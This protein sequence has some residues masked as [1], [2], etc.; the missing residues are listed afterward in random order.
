MDLI[1][2]IGIKTDNR[3]FLVIFY[4]SSQLD[5][6][7][8]T[9]TIDQ[10]EP[11][12]QLLKNLNFIIIRLYVVFVPAFIFES[13]KNFITITLDNFDNLSMESF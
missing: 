6:Y 3:P 5:V 8:L 4:F 12:V 2:L 7:V 11:G 9:H 13:Y 1:K 10:C